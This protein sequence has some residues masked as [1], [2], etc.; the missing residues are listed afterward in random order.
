MDGAYL[1][2]QSFA[3][4]FFFFFLGNM[5]NVS[6]DIVFHPGAVCQGPQEGSF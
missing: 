3:T 5:I 6:K 4:D 1:K 2:E